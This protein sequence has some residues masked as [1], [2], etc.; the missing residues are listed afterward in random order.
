MRA[1]ER[2]P[3]PFPGAWLYCGDEPVVHL[4]GVD[5]QPEKPGKLPQLEHFAFSAKGL[6]EF[7][8]A[9]TPLAAISAGWLT[10][11]RRHGRFAVRQS[12]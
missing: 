11:Y 10:S 4:V 3:F 2:P 9:P 8:L 1:G 5:E 12:H 6:K 7:G